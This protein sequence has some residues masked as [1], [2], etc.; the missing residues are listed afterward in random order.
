[1]LSRRSRRLI[2]GL[3]LAVSLSISLPVAGVGA[4]PAR[5]P[6]VTRDQQTVRQQINTTRGNQRLRGLE[7]DAVF[8]ARAQRWAQELARCRC[9]KHRSGAY[10]ATDPWYAA[11]ENVGRGWSFAQVHNAF[12]GSPPHRENMLTRRFTHVGTGVARAA[13]GE[14]FVVQAFLDRTR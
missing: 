10:G 14:I 8:A 3:L 11:A 12:L 9:L 2:A 4:A 6:V 13:N 5:G 1:M 7:M